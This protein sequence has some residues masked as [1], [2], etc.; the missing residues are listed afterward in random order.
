MIAKRPALL[1]LFLSA[2]TFA[3]AQFPPVNLNPRIGEDVGVVDI[4]EFSGNYPREVLEEYERAV[5]DAR[6]G[7]L[8]SSATRLEEVVKTMPEFY[9]ARKSLGTLYQTLGRFRD[10]EREFR[11]AKELNPRS[12]AP[13]VSLGGLFIEE[14]ESGTVTDPREIRGMLND[15]LSNLQEAVKLQPAT[16]FARYLT[17]IVYYKTRFYEEAEDQF[18]QALDTGINMSFVHLALANVYLQLEEWEP[19]VSHLDQYL[20]AYPWAANRDHVRQVRAVAMEKLEAA[21]Q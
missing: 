3:H 18:T 8:L 1:S 4:T 21:S 19:A 5:S 7:D 12:A 15:A 20:A 9:A 13:L 11:A 10:A 16:A 14:S 6:R 17:G 2:A